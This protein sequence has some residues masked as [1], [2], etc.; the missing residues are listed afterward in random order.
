[1]ILFISQ[2]SS[3]SNNGTTA[4]TSSKRQ[5][6]E[7]TPITK[8]RVEVVIPHSAEW[9][10]RRRLQT[11]MLT[12]TFFATDPNLESHQSSS[13]A[14]D[15]NDPDPMSIEEAM[16]RPDWL[17][18]RKAIFNELRSQRQRTTYS[19]PVECPSGIILMDHRWVFVRKRRADGTIERYKARLVGKG[20]LQRPF[21]DYF[22]TYAP[23]LDKITFRTLMALMASNNYDCWLMDVVTAYLYGELEK[24]LYMTVPKGERIPSHLKN[25][26]VVVHRALYGFKQSGRRWFLVLQEHLLAK[27]FRQMQSNESIFIKNDSN[28]ACVVSIYV[29]DILIIGNQP[30]VQETREMM[31]TKFEMKDLGKIRFCIGMEVDYFHNGIFVHQSGY[32][33]KQ[34]KRFSMTN[35]RK[36]STP[37]EVRSLKP[38][39]DIYGEARPGET[40]LTTRYPYLA[41]IGT[42]SYL[43]EC[44]RPDISFAVHLLAR[45]SQNPTMRHWRGVQHIFRYLSGTH[46]YGL[47][48]R[49]DATGY[50]A[51]SDAG[52]ASD[53]RNGR[54]Q[55][56]YVTLVGGTAKSWRSTRQGMTAQSSTE[57]EI[58]ALNETAKEVVSE[59]RMRNEM[60]KLLGK[61]ISKTPVTIWEDNSACLRQANQGYIRTNNNKHLSPKLFYVTDL[62]SAKVIKVEKVDSNENLADLFTKTLHG[63]KHR[64]LMERI[65][66]RKRSDLLED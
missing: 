50:E 43:A 62:I 8:R 5:T 63:P 54:S 45:H 42:L 38:E 51:Y 29:D 16:R 33:Q 40:L 18:W 13:A 60:D 44:T 28:G 25:P 48:Y 47:F 30:A 57:A 49:K 46:D 64:L 10:R 34:L 31:K 41:A 35:S 4:S 59:L 23:V 56:G 14:F 9:I 36:F 37:L 7:M 22:A 15:P 2:N 66:M 58:I 65:G 19:K 20:F 3:T 39:Q 53:S 26:C 27:Q 61:P 11:A 6:L 55:T 24:P 12:Q 1:M 21:I 52:F 32:I 17:Q